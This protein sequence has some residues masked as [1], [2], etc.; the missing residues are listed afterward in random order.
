MQKIYEKD[1]EICYNMIKE[2]ADGKNKSGGDGSERV[3]RWH[4]TSI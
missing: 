2:G 4:G 3:K 1:Y